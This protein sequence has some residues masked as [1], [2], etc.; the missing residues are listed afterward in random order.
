MLIETSIEINTLVNCVGDL[1][2]L[3]KELDRFGCPDDRKVFMID[4]TV[5]A[6]V[7]SRFPETIQCECQNENGDYIV[8]A[9][10]SMHKCKARDEE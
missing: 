9:L 7:I 10:V 6:R 2:E 3:V 4:N 5:V 8:D 1:R